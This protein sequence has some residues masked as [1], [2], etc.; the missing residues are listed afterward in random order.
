MTDGTEGSAGSGGREPAGKAELVPLWLQSDT[1]GSISRQSFAS[2]ELGCAFAL[3]ADWKATASP[4]RAGPEAI[5]VFRGENAEDWFVAS[6]MASAVPGHDMTNWVRPVLAITGFPEAA[7]QPLPTLLEWGERDVGTAYA[8][9][10]GLDEIHAFVGLARFASSLGRLYMLLARKGHL[11]WKL[12]FS[13]RSSAG[14]GRELA[15]M[16]DDDRRA[17]IVFG[18]LE[19][20]SAGASDPARE[21][22]G[23]P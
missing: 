16:R 19:F 9:R 12:F 15:C 7:V 17:A 5:G 8:S 22:R 1:D 2:P 4:S 3:P 18:S 14:A 10:L 23:Q 11:A 6:F 21:A 13:V 20:A